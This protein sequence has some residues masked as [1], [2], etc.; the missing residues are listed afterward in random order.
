MKEFYTCYCFV[1]ALVDVKVLTMFW[2][3]IIELI[4]TVLKDKMKL[5]NLVLL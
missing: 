5:S 4:V 2:Y 3:S 1:Y